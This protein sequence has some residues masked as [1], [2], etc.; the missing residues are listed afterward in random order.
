MVAEQMVIASEYW[1]AVAPFAFGDV[2]GLVAGGDGRVGLSDG[3]FDVHGRII[4]RQ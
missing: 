1:H 3:V 4:L 2:K